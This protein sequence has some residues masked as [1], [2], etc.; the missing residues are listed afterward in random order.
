MDQFKTGYRIIMLI[1]RKND[2]GKLNS[3]RKGTRC[4]TENAIHFNNA[5]DALRKIKVD[6]D[7]IYCTVNSRN[8]NKAIRLFKKRQLDNDYASSSEGE[9]FYCDIQNR[10]ISCFQNPEARNSKNFL[11][12]IDSQR[13]QDYVNICTNLETVTNI[14]Y[15]KETPNG[16]HLITEPFD[17]SRFHHSKATILKDGMLFL[18]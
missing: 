15:V 17:R 4:I 2:E 9:Q 5:L 13:L 1:N 3:D 6:G 10:F 7:R 8:I 11:I 16:F 14:L 12:D 18:E